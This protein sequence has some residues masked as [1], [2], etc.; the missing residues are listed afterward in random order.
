MLLVDS[1]LA[2][3]YG[4]HVSG[5][6]S[7]QLVLSGSASQDSY[8]QVLATVRYINTADEPTAPNAT[9]QR[10]VDF[11]VEDESFNA[12]ASTVIILHPKNN[13]PN[14]TTAVERVVT[15]DESTRNP[16]H[17]FTS[18]DQIVDPDSDQVVWVTVEINPAPDSRDNLS[19]A[20][21]QG[22]SITRLARATP[23]DSTCFPFANNN[24]AQFINVSGVAAL[25]AYEEALHN[26]TFSNDCPDLELASRTV[27]VTLSDGISSNTIRVFVN[28]SAF[29][30]PPLCYF[31]HWPVSVIET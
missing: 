13:P 23:T 9:S 8:R 28:I 1:I 7:S 15:F 2:A 25:S 27:Q 10:T 29:D 11:L 30:D 20:E 22:L 5:T 19:V 21:V 16:V 17:L 24:T 6:E 14:V 12:T 31:G 18:S 3:S 4:I 26:L